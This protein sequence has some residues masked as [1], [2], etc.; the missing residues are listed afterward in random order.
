MHEMALCESI[1]QLITEQ[2]RAQSFARVRRVWLEVGSLAAVEI[3]ALRFGFDV[4][5]RD[6]LAEGAVLE[7]V[8]IPGRAWCMPC[9]ESCTLA[10]RGDAC[11]RCGGYQ[12]QVIDG[13]QM[14][15]KELEVS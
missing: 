10:A 12:L 1:L 11:P 15:V 3:P 8:E 14:R 2:A 4:V 9:G 5:T 6:T 7:I 13:T